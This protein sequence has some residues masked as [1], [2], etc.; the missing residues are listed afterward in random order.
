MFYDF[1]IRVCLWD[2]KTLYHKPTLFR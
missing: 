1:T 2:Y